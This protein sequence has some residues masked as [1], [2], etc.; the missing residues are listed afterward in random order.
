MALTARTF[1]L[2]VLPH[3]TGFHEIGIVLGLVILVQG[4]ETS[5]YLGAAY[6]RPTRV[7]TMR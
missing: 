3:A 5:R 7:R 6:D 2:P 1:T 4:F